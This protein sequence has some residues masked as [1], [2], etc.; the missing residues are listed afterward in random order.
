MRFPPAVSFVLWV[1]VFEVWC[2]TLLSHR[3]S[4]CPLVYLCV[5]WTFL[6]QFLHVFPNPGTDRQVS[7]TLS[8]SILAHT[9]W[10]GVCIPIFT[11]SFTVDVVCHWFN[12]DFF[13]FG[14]YAIK[15]VCSYVSLI[16]SVASSWNIL[17]AFLKFVTW[18]TL[19]VLGIVLYLCVLVL[20]ILTSLFGVFPTSEIT[21]GCTS[22]VSTSFQKSHFWQFSYFCCNC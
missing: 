15:V 22:D 18:L 7:W 5:K 17:G 13:F 6:C 4:F 14:V 9:S 20:S 8:W 21:W 11:C 12:C 16:F 2:C 10:L 19:L 1:S 3:F